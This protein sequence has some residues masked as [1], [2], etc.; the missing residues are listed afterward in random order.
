MLITKKQY[1]GILLLVFAAGFIF[2]A[3]C[4]SPE[5]FRGTEMPADMPVLDF[6][7]TDQFGE[8]FMLSEHRGKVSLIFFG[9]TFCPDVCPTTLATWRRVEEVLGEDAKN[10]NF[11][12][13]TVD[14]QRDTQQKLKNHLSVFSDDFIG[15]TGS[16][17]ALTAVYNEFGIYREVQELADSGAGY[18]V[19][20][21]SR[22][23]G[24]DRQGKWRLGID[25]N[26]PAEDI[27]HDVRLL[28]AGN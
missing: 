15:L 14:P 28:L 27:A 3:G 5:P 10:V 17:E 26:A 2:M 20:H 4:R 8:P 19:N 25:F 23:F 12:Y 24:L 9:Y 22:V 18:L 21:T 11:I 16:E 1:P 13:I 6:T 7:L